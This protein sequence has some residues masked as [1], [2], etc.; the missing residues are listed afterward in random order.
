M[1]KALYKHL[2]FAIVNE[3]DGDYYDINDD[4]DIGD[5][6]FDDDDEGNDVKYG[7]DKWSLLPL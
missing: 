5:D 2:T 3:D 7:D 4:D 1:W 6:N